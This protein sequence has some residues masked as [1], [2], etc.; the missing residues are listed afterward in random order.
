MAGRGGAAALSVL[1]AFAS[2]IEQCSPKADIATP[3]PDVAH[4]IAKLT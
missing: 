1:L 2:L 4:Q 3:Q